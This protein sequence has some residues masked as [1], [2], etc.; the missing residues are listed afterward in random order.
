MVILYIFSNFGT[1]Y[2]EKSG[3]PDGRGK[4]MKIYVCNQSVDFQR[5]TTN[6]ADSE[7]TW[8]GYVAIFE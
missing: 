1:L 3:N 5:S 4:P 7:V 8:L 2:K 6:T